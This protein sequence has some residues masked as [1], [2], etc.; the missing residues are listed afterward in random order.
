MNENGKVDAMLIE[1]FVRVKVLLYYLL[2]IIESVEG[3]GFM[4]DLRSLK[5]SLEQG[6]ILIHQFKPELIS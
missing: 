3:A 2:K 4:K 5:N 1:K 6:F